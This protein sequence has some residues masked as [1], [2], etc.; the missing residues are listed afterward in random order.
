MEIPKPKN[1]REWRATIGL[2][3][4]RF[5]QLLSIFESAY[6]SVFEKTIEERITDCPG[7]FKFRTYR[8]LLFFTLFSLKS[9]LGYDI[10][11]FLFEMDFSN[12]KRNQTAGLKVLSKA[13]E[14]SGHLPEREFASPEA[15]HAHFERHKKLILDGT[16]QRTTRPRDRDL[17]KSMYSGKKKRTR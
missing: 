4:K 12:A 6:I 15:F 8:D 7:D 10:L 14:D 5:I 3:K 13:L 11:G 16:E 9:G 17:Q 1:D 2:D